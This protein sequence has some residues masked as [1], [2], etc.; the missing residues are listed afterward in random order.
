MK[1]VLV[2]ICAAGLLWSWQAEPV[3]SF[4]GTVKHLDS[5]TLTLSRPD[6]DDMDIL[7]THKTRYYSGSKKIKRDQI[8]VGDLV[9]VDTT[10]DPTRKPEA[11][12]VRLLDKPAK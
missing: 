5:G 9:S 7:C 8:K 1:Y 12:N 10:L 11:V 6:E 3:A 4:T 2:L